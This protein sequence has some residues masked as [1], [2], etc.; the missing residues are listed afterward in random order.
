MALRWK[1]VL[2]AATKAKSS[3]DRIPPEQRRRMLEEAKTKVQ[4]HG[5]VAARKVADSAKTH[6]PAIAQKAA[7]TA[8]K[9]TEAARAQAPGIAR[10]IAE[11]LERARKTDD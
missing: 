9:A 3:W 1:L 4:T 8:Q 10:R 2:A 6:G 5:P 11:A 7:E